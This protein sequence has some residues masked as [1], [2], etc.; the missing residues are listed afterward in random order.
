MVSIPTL[1][2][3]FV[4]NFLALAL[5]WTYVVRSYPSFGAARFW[6]ASSYMATV[7]AFIL[8]L[9]GTVDPWIPVVLGNTLLL[10]SG[11]VGAL[12]IERFYN[13]AASWGASL[14]L[15]AMTAGGL[16]A[17]L[18]W[19][20]IEMRIVVYS[21]GQGLTLVAMLAMLSKR[22]EAGGSVGARLVGLVA[23]TGIAV[24]AMRAGFAVWHVGGDV[25]FLEYNAVQAVMM[26]AL[27]FLSM[28]WN[29]GFL[30][31]AIDRLRGEVADLALMDDLT[32]I[33]NRRHLLQRLSAE[34]AL[35]RRTGVPFAL[36]AVDLDGF[37]EINDSYGHAAGDEYLRLFT[38]TAQSRLRPGD[39]LARAGGDE[40]C[41]VLPATALRDAAALARE[42]LEACR[43]TFAHWDG[44][45]VPIAAS[46][47]VAL[48][49][50]LMG[51]HPERLIA[52]AD[53]ALY[54]AKKQGKNRL[55]VYDEAPAPVQ[56][57]EA[58]HPT[59]LLMTG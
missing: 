48:W 42:V 46:I 28:V 44:A 38:A 31:M 39:M 33:A 57:G 50:P 27:V 37:K 9:R 55:A 15:T 16:A 47:G 23:L 32:G 41:I 2:G 30:L 36:L 53:Q 13:R 26:L 10:F 52:A 34:C 51:G 11:W 35:S 14:L 24:H 45:S 58:N 8:T 17:Y 20:N 59:K 25:G 43:A 56:G 21:L 5:V 6:A 29:F 54:A 1:W 12:G 19:D 3:V 22:N 7:G 18:A 49:S 40:F 4:V